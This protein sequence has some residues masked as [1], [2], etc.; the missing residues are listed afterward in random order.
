M[1]GLARYIPFLNRMQPT[2]EETVPT[3]S[4]LLE[5]VGEV[6]ERGQHPHR[7]LG[8]ALVGLH[9]TPLGAFQVDAAA[10]SD[11]ADDGAFQ[12]DFRSAVKIPVV[13]LPDVGPFVPE[14]GL[15]DFASPK[16][17]SPAA[18]FD[19]AKGFFRVLENL[20]DAASA[21]TGSSAKITKHKLNATCTARF[22]TS[23]FVIPY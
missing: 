12:T 5:I 22:M 8:A 16:I 9:G 21:E 1:A 4:S 15:A 3:H 10:R 11:V 18:K 17:V 14:D 2:C 20:I 6:V 7:F 23:L 19:S 13:E